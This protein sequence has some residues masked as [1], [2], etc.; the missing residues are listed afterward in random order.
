MSTFVK[1]GAVVAMTLAKESDINNLADAIENAFDL[2]PDE[3]RLARGTTNYVVSTGS[4]NAYSVSMPVAPTSYADG[5]EVIMKA[6]HTN[7]G[8]ATLDVDG[9]GAKSLRRQYGSALAEGD[10]LAN[11]IIPFRY[12]ATSGCFEM[13]MNMAVGGITDVSIVAGIADDITTVAGISAD[14]TAV[15]GISADVTTVVGME[16]GISDILTHA[17]AVDAVSADLAGSNHV[18]TCGANMEVLEDVAGLVLLAET[19]EKTADYTLTLADAGK[20]VAMNKSGPAV[21]SVPSNAAVAF[22]VGSVVGVYN[23]SADAV[24]VAGDGGVTVRNAG[25]VPQYGE[26]SLRK[27]AE[28]EWVLVGALE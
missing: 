2:L 4:G 20:L 16:T 10:I 8:A 9:L 17:T 21:L 22:P 23:M 27:R 18:G 6:N 13:Q 19:A 25:D 15:A 7:T 14:V 11:K 3:Y 5:Y 12:N 28:N 24:T 1:P 26:I